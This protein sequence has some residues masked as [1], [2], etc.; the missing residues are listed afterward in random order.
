MPQQTFINGEAL[1]SVR[2]KLNS[3][4]TDAES[5]LTDIETGLNF[6][7]IQTKA[8]FPTPVGGVITLEAGKAYLVNGDID[9]TGDRLVTGGICALFG[10][11]SETASITSTGLAAGTPL[12]TSNYTLPIQ[13]ISF[14]DVDTGFYVSDDNSPQET[15]AIDWYA[16]NFVNIPN[17]GEVGTVDNFIYDASAV[18]NS[19]GMKFTG[20]VGTI[21]MSNSIFVGDGAAG[22]IIDVQSTCT[23]TR[24]FRIIYSSVV[25]F[26][27]SV[28]VDVDGTATIPVEGYILDTVNFSGGGTYQAGTFYTDEKT[29]FIECRNIPNTAVVGNM[30]MSNNA[31]ETTISATDTPVKV[32]GTT[33]ANA[34]NQKFDH[35]AGTQ[36]NR[37]TYTGAL[38]RDIQI[39]AVASIESTNNRVIGLYIAKNGTALNDSEM[40]ATTSGS[41]KAESITVQT[42]VEAAENDYFEVWV[43]NTTNTDNVTVTFLNVI[44]KGLN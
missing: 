28:G 36:P 10:T 17:I 26:G 11:S 12:L 15:V 27:S 19:R 7:N 9:L 14:K 6:T 20:T 35:D 25:A 22:N 31:T 2:S 1:S 18:L 39:T 21:G 40:Y 43:E 24:R 34:V 4:A 8:D 44:A 37:L 33:T 30:F 16:T 42:V 5:R 38:S 41:G 13:N 3:N 23:V 29:R 32:A